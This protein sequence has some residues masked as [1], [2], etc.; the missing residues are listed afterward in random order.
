MA[1]IYLN[2]AHLDAV[3]AAPHD[4]LAAGNCLALF[5]AKLRSE[6]VPGDAL[7]EHI[8]KAFEAAA[9]APASKR[10]KMLTDALYLTAP[11][12]RVA[13]DYIKIGMDVDG[14]IGPKTSAT[15][16]IDAIADE[17]GI[18]SRTVRRYFEEYKMAREEHDAIS[19]SERDARDE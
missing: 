17:N 14:L 6:Y 2:V 4:P 18:S 7:S 9:A 11:R 5:A 15:A 16:A 13:G 8:A 10:A 12:K 19:R 3:S 1:K